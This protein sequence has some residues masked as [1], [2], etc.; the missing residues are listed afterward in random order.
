MVC[1][2]FIWTVPLRV[3]LWAQSPER[4]QMHLLATP[5][6]T[7][8]L[9]SS[10]HAP[11]SPAVA[12]PHPPANHSA[13]WRA[14]E[15]RGYL[16][17]LNLNFKTPSL[18]FPLFNQLFMESANASKGARMAS[19]HSGSP[20]LDSLFL[21][22]NLWVYEALP[23][24]QVSPEDPQSNRRWRRRRRRGGVSDR[25]ERCP[26]QRD[27]VREMTAETEGDAA[28]AGRWREMRSGVLGRGRRMERRGWEM[29]T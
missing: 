12:L 20:E 6:N 5:W 18:H 22:H 8:R 24:P 3:T 23:F 13:Y 16:F 15:C 9:I 25:R 1:G 10:L 19:K 7:L 27:G 4:T 2:V 17:D 21:T 11:V 14:C 26:R 29:Q 28:R